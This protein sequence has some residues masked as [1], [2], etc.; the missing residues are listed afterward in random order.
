M[1]EQDV[2]L[3]IR[4]KNEASAGFADVGKNLNALNANLRTAFHTMGEGEQAGRELATQ[5]KKTADETNYLRNEIDN[6]TDQLKLFGEQG[7]QAAN[8]LEE[9]HDPARRASE[10]QRLLAEALRRTKTE[11]V[12]LNDAAKVRIAENALQDMTDTLNRLS[13]AGQRAAGHLANVTDIQK[14]NA[15]AAQIMRAEMAE[16]GGGGIIGAFRRLDDNMAVSQAKFA[17][18]PTSMQTL[19]KGAVPALATSLGGLAAGGGVLSGALGDMAGSMVHAAGAAGSM[20]LGAAAAALAVGAGL[21]AAVGAASLAVG[22]FALDSL[23]V[24]REQSL[25]AQAANDNLEKSTRQLQLAVGGL[26]EDV[27]QTTLVEQGLAKLTRDAADA[28]D[29]LT[30]SQ[31]RNTK[32]TALQRIQRQNMER[33]QEHALWIFGPL[34]GGYR[35]T[36]DLLAEVGQEEQERVK[37]LKDFSATTDIVTRTIERMNDELL[38]TV[39]SSENAT[40]A[41]L[42]GMEGALS[43]AADLEEQIRKINE[44]WD[45]S[46]ALV[47]GV[48]VGAITEAAPA[49]L[50]PKKAGKKSTLEERLK[51]DGFFKFQTPGED[52]GIDLGFEQRL[53]EL[54]K[55]Q[56]AMDTLRNTALSEITQAANVAAIAFDDLGKKIEASK[57]RDFQAEAKEGIA[58]QLEEINALLEEY[59]SLEEAGLSLQEIQRAEMLMVHEQTAAWNEYAATLLHAGD[60]ANDLKGALGDQLKGAVLDLGYAFGQAAAQSA[61]MSNIGEVLVSQVQNLLKTLAPAVLQLGLSIEAIQ[62]GWAPA[63][64][65]AGIALSVVAG[66]LAAYKSGG[67]RSGSTLPDNTSRL[68][69]IAAE[70]E[71]QRQDERDRVINVFIGEERVEGAF[72]RTMQ[73]AIRRGRITT[74]Q[75]AGFLAA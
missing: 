32:E 40:K 48:A 28:M 64:V 56:A 43:R 5:L 75:P 18:L 37:G 68:R 20:A 12:Q 3:R 9:I 44:A 16:K 38:K 66:T 10:G 11:M 58:A 71:A 23:G 50:T 65:G 27:L 30:S 57:G 1:T 4:L 67:G 8:A 42:T 69:S 17:A 22:K 34:L 55:F 74:P 19:A 25:A 14:R 7:L 61:G 52:T 31:E 15:A 6:I 13:P 46:T 62:S 59:D 63:I 70:F 33:E 72:T 21:A 26:V 60:V 45:D 35:L 24:W 51:K 54:L 39:G 53:D 36:R 47:R 41:M 29:E 73:N 49:A 2:T